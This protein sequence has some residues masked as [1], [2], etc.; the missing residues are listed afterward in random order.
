MRKV[1][2]TILLLLCVVPAFAREKRFKP[3][4]ARQSA[5]P[6]FHRLAP[7]DVRAQ[8]V[9][10]QARAAK[11]TPSAIVDN[12]SS[13]AIVFP[14]AGNASG[15]NG[16]Y[17]RSDVTLVNLNDAEQDIIVWWF[18][19][20]NPGGAVSFEGT[21]D[22]GPPFTFVDF[23][24]QEL[25]LSG[26]GAIL[27]FPVDSTGE[28]DP[29]GALDGYSRIWSPAP[30]GSAGTFSQPFPAVDFDHLVGEYDALILG[31]RQD[32]GFRTNYGIVNMSGVDLPFAITIF[33]NAGTVVSEFTVTVRVGEMILRSLPAGNFGNMSILVSVA[34]DIPGD[35][36]EWTTFA[37]STD[38]FN[39]DGWVSIGAKP[40][41]DDDLDSEF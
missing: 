34:D 25:E 3:P 38:N 41:D 19:N 13:R 9:L 7:D 5:S 16:T 2:F 40:Y 32:T 14:A 18:P 35:S 27:V 28:L 11:V 6:A 29:D 17:F 20:G 22:S 15:A 23:V 4:A 10:A 21:L 26:V 1:S 33:N 30:A 36:F 24:G 39:G 12:K 8:R 31:V 37:S